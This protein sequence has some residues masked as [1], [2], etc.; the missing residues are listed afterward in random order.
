MIRKPRQGTQ[1]T[2]NRARQNRNHI[3]SHFSTSLPNI[4]VNLNTLPEDHTGNKLPQGAKMIPYLT[5]F[6]PGSFGPSLA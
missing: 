1:A 6:R 3:K 5:L 2:P 4:A